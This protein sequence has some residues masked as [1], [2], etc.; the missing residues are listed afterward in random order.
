[1]RFIIWMAV[2]IAIYFMYGYKHAQM[3]AADESTGSKEETPEK[4]P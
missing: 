2:G 4:S 1:L 3:Q